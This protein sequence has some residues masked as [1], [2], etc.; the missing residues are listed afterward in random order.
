MLCPP[1]QAQRWTSKNMKEVTKEMGESIRE[2]IRLA[3]Y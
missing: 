2:K 3:A 1:L